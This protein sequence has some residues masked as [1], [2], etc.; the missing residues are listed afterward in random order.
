[1]VYHDFKAIQLHI[2]KTGG[3][4]IEKAFGL[5][6]GDIVTLGKHDRPS[7]IIKKNGQSI[8]DEYYK[9]S[10]VRNPWDRLVSMFFFRRDY[11]KMYPSNFPFEEFLFDWVEKNCNWQQYCWFE[12]RME[13]FD[14]I[15]RFENLEADFRH[16]CEVIGAEG[17]E[18]P[19]VYKTNHKHYS[20]YYDNFMR[21]ELARIAAKDIEIFGYEFDDRR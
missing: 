17:L 13:E 18:L 12:D 10:F 15:G 6:Y 1:M 20:H 14:F 3:T 7:D 8:W 2:G 21:D 19:H 5:K 11:R 16:I 4:S 9:F